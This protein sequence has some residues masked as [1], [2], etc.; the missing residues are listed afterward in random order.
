MTKEE[1]ESLQRRREK[2]LKDVVDSPLWVNGSVVET[3]RKQA[4]KVKPFNYLSRSIKGK[5]KVTYVSSSSLDAFKKA[6]A[7]GM[8]VRSLL[9]EAGEIT[10][11]LLKVAGKDVQ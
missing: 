11:Q 1:R 10:I 5:N 6:A 7:Q 3:R 8:H 4:G 2:L 9:A